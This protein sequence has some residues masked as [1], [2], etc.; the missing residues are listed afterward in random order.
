MIRET[1]LPIKEASICR[2]S[3]TRDDMK[4]ET[5]SLFDGLIDIYLRFQYSIP[6]TAKRLSDAEDYRTVA[7]AALKEMVRQVGK[8]EYSENGMMKSGVIVRHLVLPGERKNSIGVIKIL[9]DNFA[10]DEIL[11]S[12][13]SQYTPQND[14]VY[15]LSRRI[16][17]FEYESVREYAEK[18]GF[19]GFSQEFTSQARFY[20]RFENNITI[21]IRILTIKLLCVIISVSNKTVLVN[22][23]KITKPLTL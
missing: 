4:P 5:L 10:S 16:T 12:I 11:L 1:L 14:A 7:I 2:L 6:D 21:T 15:P 22:V 9:A 3:A 17:T 13:M 19:D 8:A 20:S 23:W 18:C